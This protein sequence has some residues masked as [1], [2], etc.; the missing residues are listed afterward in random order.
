[1][2]A[3]P[4][5]VCSLALA[6]AA[7]LA[8]PPLA[9]LALVE[10]QVE[11]ASG[12]GAWRPAVEGAWLSPG[13]G[14]RTGG[15]GLVRLELPWMAITL[16]HG[17]RLRLPDALVLSAALDSGRALVEGQQLD[18]LKLVTREA[19]VR[20]RGRAVVRREGGRTLVTCL[21]GIFHV[22]ARRSTVTLAR[23]QGT[24]VER[25]GAPANPQPVPSP[26][27]EALWPG[28]DPVYVAPGGPL[29]L[30]WSGEGSFQI[31]LL[32]VGKDVVLLQRDVGSPPVQITV[33]WE[34]AFRWR[35]SARD[36]RGLEG[37]PSA[38]GLIAVE[39]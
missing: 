30:R 19:E 34:G 2:P 38:E 20:G 14:L 17:S 23:G 5:L 11:V 4:T 7:G 8:E 33:P 26:P 39:R 37:L 6:A 16:A 21:S 29:Q 36:A 18:T 24:L 25:G 12:A 35:V 13:Q 22:T 32:P 28:R 9:R 10:Q 3:G 31:E 27:G 15:D 1:M